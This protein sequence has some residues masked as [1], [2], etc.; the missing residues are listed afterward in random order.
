MTGADVQDLAALTFNYTESA[1]DVWRPSAY[2]V[3]GLHGPATNIVLDGLAEAASRPD[4]SPVGVVVQGQRGTGKTHLLGWVRE[5][6]Q[7]QGGYFVLAG[8]LDAKGFWESMVVSILDSL[9]RPCEDGQVQLARLLDRLASQVG[10]TRM[11]RRA[12]IGKRAVTRDEL[13]TFVAALRR[14]D[15]QVGRE[16]QDTARALVLL[17]GDDLGLQ[18]LGEAFLSSAPEGQPGERAQWGIRQVGRTPQE[19]VR[20]IS[21]LMA[22][23]GPTIIAVDQIDPLVAQSSVPTQGGARTPGETLMI[24]RIAGGLM[25]LREVTRRT[26]TV[27]TCIPATWTLVEDVAVD[28]VRD[29]FRQ[30]VQLKTIPDADTARTLVVRRFEVQYGAAGIKPPYPT[31]PVRPEAFEQAPGYTPRQLLIRIDRH[32]HACLLDGEVTELDDLGLTPSVPQAPASVRAAEVQ[33]HHPA[34]A[35]LRALDVRFKELREALPPVI[36]QVSEDALMPPLLAAGLTAWITEQGEAGM[37]FG[38]DSPPSAKPPLH[39][40]LRRTLDEAREDEIHWAFR[41]V[42]AEHGNAALNRIRRASVAAGLDVE[43][44]KRRLFLLRNRPWSKG[45]A[46]QAAIIAFERAGGRTLRVSEND[47]R[48]LAALRALLAENPSDLAAW[49]VARRPTAEIGFLSEALTGAWSVPLP[50]AGVADDP[51]RPQSGDPARPQSGDPASPQSGDAGS[52]QPVGP[53]SAQAGDAESTQPVVAGSAH[54]RGSGV[55]AARMPYLSVGRRLGDG[56]PV[57]VALEALRKHVTIFAGSGSGKTVLIRRLVEECALLG[58]SAI[59]LDPNNDLARLGERWPEPPPAW[60][61]GDA[62]KADDYLAG[63]DVVVWTPGRSGG[64]PLSFHPLPDFTGLAGDPDEFAEAVEAAVGFIVPRV[65]L[66]ANTNKAQLGQAVLRKALAY[67]GRRGATSLKGFAALLSDLP[68]G[69]SELAG[70]PRIAADLA[71]SL[72]AAMDNDPLFGGVGEPVDPGLLLTPAPGRRARVSVISLAGLPGLEQRQSFVSRLQM[73]LFV[74]FKRHPVQDRP[75][76]ALLVMDEAQTFAPATGPAAATRSTVLLASQARK[77]GLGLVFATQA[78]KSLHN[79]IPGNAATQF[80]GLLNAPIQITAAREMARSKGGDVPDVS[81]LSTGEF[82]VALEGE[83]FVKVRT[84]MCLSR[85]PKAPLTTEE[86]M[87]KSRGALRP[88]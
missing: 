73:E 3:E 52:P 65:R 40:R 61:D 27:V 22:L 15:A 59:V 84:P 63:T 16:S 77:Y 48:V 29:R 53:G 32:V 62:R 42:S 69:V 76:G 7:R 86:V 11:V 44:P 50:A 1:D 60:E 12:I 19:I 55:T 4:A 56:A 47:L 23:T 85:H 25:A 54:A 64:R 78:P 17:A 21:R 83:A 75:L 72:T 31:W 18:D 87:E 24:E 34:A 26:L 6:A 41:A 71:Q 37:S 81:R 79:Q 9:S 14:F 10:V 8:L 5:T 70:A 38:V 68:D 39:A 13:E 33:A 36:D 51:A 45:G 46:T 30:A 67:Y 80:F 20:D 66:D 28:T 74:W 82:Y 35:D 43:V 88:A 49:L 2:H 58:V 57:S